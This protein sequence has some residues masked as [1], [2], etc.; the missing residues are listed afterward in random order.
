MHNVY[1][2]NDISITTS[3]EEDKENVYF[4]NQMSIIACQKKEAVKSLFEQQNVY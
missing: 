2:A 3:K 4:K 1:S